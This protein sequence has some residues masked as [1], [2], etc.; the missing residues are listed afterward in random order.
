[1]TTWKIGMRAPAE[2][3]NAGVS[4]CSHK[5]AVSGK[6]MALLSSSQSAARSPATE[7]RRCR[8]S[9][10]DAVLELVVE[11]PPPDTDS[12]SAPLG[13]TEGSVEASWA[14][15]EPL[16]LPSVTGV[17]WLCAGAG[18]GAGAC[19]TSVFAAGVV[20]ISGCLPVVIVGREREEREGLIVAA[21]TL[22][23]REAQ[24]SFRSLTPAR[25]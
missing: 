17:C 7:F 1:M 10:A 23:D 6:V 8:R 25:E 15:W 21:S 22:T 9:L 2:N 3:I 20:D 16:A 11:L 19:D 18:A 14:V 12:P 5:A 13:C 4:T 24:R